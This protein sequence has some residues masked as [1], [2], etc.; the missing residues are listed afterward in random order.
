MRSWR[1][2]QPRPGH[3]SFGRCPNESRILTFYCRGVSI[4]DKSFLS[5]IAKSSRPYPARPSDSCVWQRP[6][7]RGKQAD[8]LTRGAYPTRPAIKRVSLHRRV[9]CPNHSLWIGQPTCIHKWRPGCRQTCAL[10][11]TVRPQ[12][13]HQPQRSYHVRVARVRAPPT[14]NSGN[15]TAFARFSMS[16]LPQDTGVGSFGRSSF[17]A[18]N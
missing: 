5:S 10:L 7:K 2:L 14:L 9:P 16:S 18:G 15:T 11:H 3:K 1:T 8:R 13:A 17:Q 12:V 4:L 6:D